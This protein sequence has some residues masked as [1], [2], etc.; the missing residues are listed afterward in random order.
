MKSNA[1]AVFGVSKTTFLNRLKGTLP[2]PETRV[3]GYKLTVF[4]EDVL[5]K[6]LLDAYK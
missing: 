2:Q 4:E 6:H 3:N 5:S 1:V